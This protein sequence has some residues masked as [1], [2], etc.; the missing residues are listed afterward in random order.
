MCLQAGVIYGKKTPNQA[1][2]REGDP[3]ICDITNTELCLIK[4]LRRV[5]NKIIYDNIL[6]DRLSPKL[7]MESTVIQCSYNI[8][9]LQ[10][11]I[12]YGKKTPNQARSREGVPPIRDITNTVLC[13]I[14]SL[15]R[16]SN[17]IIYDNILLDRLSP[18][19]SMES[20]VIQCSYNIM[21]LQTGVIYGK[22]TPNQARSRKEITNTELYLIKSLRRI[23]N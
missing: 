17:K 12:I 22:E 16:V 19:L 2:S 8:M 9:C 15:R 11:G 20:T 3:P 10:T 14:K 7:N 5:S 13:L 1:M 18:K 4:S 23:S 6:L 21:C